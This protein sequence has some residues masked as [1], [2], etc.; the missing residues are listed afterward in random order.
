MVAVIFACASKGN[1]TKSESTP[2]PKESLE[3]ENTAKLTESKLLYENTCNRCHML[4]NPKQYDKQQWVSILDRMQHKAKI[5]DAD[6]L[7]IYNYI[8]SE[9]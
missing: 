3:V 4:Y 9:M 7:R 8:V 2:Q 1:L 6:K 5:N